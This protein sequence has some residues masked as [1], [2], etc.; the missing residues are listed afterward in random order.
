MNNLGVHI[1]HII[2]NHLI[3]IQV[4]GRRNEGTLGKQEQ[5]YISYTVYLMQYTY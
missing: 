2:I 5:I 3:Y 1:Q 4:K